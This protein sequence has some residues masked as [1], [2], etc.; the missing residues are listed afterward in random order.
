MSASSRRWVGSAD[1][2]QRVELYST[3]LCRSV[4]TR[5]STRFACSTSMTNRSSLRP[6]RPSSSVRTTG[7]RSRRPRARRRGSPGCRSVRSTAS[8]PTPTCPVGTVSIPRIRPRGVSGPPVRPLHREG[9]RGGR[10]RGNLGGRLRLPPE[11]DGN[12]SVHATREP[13]PQRG[14]AVSESRGAR[15]EREAALAVH[16]TVAAGCR[17][18]QRGLRDRSSESRRRGDIRLHR[19]GT[20]RRDV[21]RVRDGAQ[22]RERRRDHRR[23]LEGAGGFHSIGEPGIRA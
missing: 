15:R 10:E 13:R 16:R 1:R 2:R 11:G 22:L 17:R 14:R 20:A 23:P 3:S 21:G 18:A 9:E 6:P 4:C 7:S 19:G 12:P 8:S 5:P